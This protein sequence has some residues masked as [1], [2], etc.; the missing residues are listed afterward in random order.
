MEESEDVIGAFG[1]S[2]GE[3]F[4]LGTELFGEFLGRMTHG[5]HWEKILH[6]I[7]DRHPDLAVRELIE[8]VSDENLLPWKYK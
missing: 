7:E 2:E 4:H 6:D 8:S 1:L 3:R 5:E